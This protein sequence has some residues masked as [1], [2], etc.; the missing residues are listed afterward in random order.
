MAGNPV[1]GVLALQGAF[2]AHLEKFQ[3]IGVPARPIR[4]ADDLRRVDALALP[5]GESSAMLRLMEPEGLFELIGERAAAGTPIFATCAG[6]IVLAQ[7]VCPA[8]PSLGVLDV[9]VER[10]AYGR[11]VHSSVESL[12][13][14]PAVRSILVAEGVF[15]RAPKVTRVGPDIEVLAHREADPVLLR[16]PGV[17]A[18]TYHPELSSGAACHRFFLEAFFGKGS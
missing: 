6:V 5:G 1:V 17:L 12:T 10:N 3:S 4:T 14:A 16:A 7:T 15:I 8:Q 11:Q 13:L 9:D 2:G 18:A